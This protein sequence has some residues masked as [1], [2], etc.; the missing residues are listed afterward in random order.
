MSN[1]NLVP[2]A[3]KSGSIGIPNKSWGSGSFYVL[4]NQDPSSALSGSFSGSF[5]GTFLSNILTSSI[6]NF[7]SE[8]SRSVSDS[9][10]NSISNWDELL[11]KPIGLLSGSTQITN[12]GFISESFTTLGTNI[13]SGSSQVDYNNITNR[14]NGIYSSSLQ[15]SNINIS[16]ISNFDSEVSRSAALNGFGT[17]GSG[18]SDYTL[19]SN[20]PSGILSSSEQITN[21]PTSSITNFNTEV[22]RSAASLGF[23]NGSSSSNIVL[24]YSCNI[25]G[26]SVASVDISGLDL[27]P[28]Y[29]VQIVSEYLK[30]TAVT[31]AVFMVRFNNISANYLNTSLSTG[32]ST[33]ATLTLAWSSTLNASYTFLDATIVNPSATNR[34][35]VSSLFSF[36]SSGLKSGYTIGTFNDN[37]SQSTREAA[38]TRLTFLCSTGNI[39]VGSNFKIFG[40]KP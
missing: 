21:L 19:L 17:G 12:L 26:S 4:N 37:E 28:Y 5:Q 14:P 27:S 15:L 22:S 31:N 34:R 1:Q 10:F 39:D 6:L 25:T 3:D 29:K 35:K 2:R 24:I 11:G 40:Y 8:V 13:V 20:I 9:G 23:G 38:I 30:T 18:V 16:S 36:D 7:D 32:T 33:G